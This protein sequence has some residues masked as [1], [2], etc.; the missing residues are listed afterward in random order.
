[1]FALY[2]AVEEAESKIALLFVSYKT[3]TSFGI[4]KRKQLLIIQKIAV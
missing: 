2:L 4:E 3:K 1:M